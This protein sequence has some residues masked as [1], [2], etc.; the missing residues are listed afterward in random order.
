MKKSLVALAALAVVGAASAQVSIT[1]T[2]SFSYQ[3]DLSGTHGFALSDSYLEFGATEDLGGGTALTLKEGLN[4]NGRGTTGSNAASGDNTS[5]SVKGGFGAVTVKTYESD[6]PLAAVE[7]L[8]GASLSTGMFDSN[9][10]GLGKRFRNAL[11]YSL[12]EIS[13]FTPALTYVTLA[14]QYAST[15]SLDAK[16]KVV[17]AVT[18]KNGP[19]T[20]YAEY[21]VFN[22]TYNAT[23]D[24][25][26][27]QPTVTALY[28]F[29]VATAG[30]G[31]TKASNDQ[32]TYIL[33]VTVPVGAVSLGLATASYQGTSS[34]ATWTEASAA[35]AVSKRTTLKASFGALNDAAVA[36][37]NGYSSASTYGLSTG[38]AQNCEYRVGIFHSF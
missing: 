13:G 29:G 35:Y 8:S 9:A 4:T 23:A 32:A 24:D 26:V 1:G 34:T 30:F 19:L 3:N 18:Y 28:D 7:G 38:L 25:Q 15:S 17:P 22:A 6:G 37:A 11:S 20:A 10:V 14:G 21:A 31:W 2:T 12:P 33:G 36:K 27:T 5:L 16:T